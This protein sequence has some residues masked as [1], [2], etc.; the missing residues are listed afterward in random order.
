MAQKKAK[1][2]TAYIRERAGYQDE[3]AGKSADSTQKTK[4]VYWDAWWTHGVASTAS[5]LSL[6]STQTARAE[7]AAAIAQASS[8]L[9][10][11][12]RTAADT[13]DAVDKDLADNFKDQMQDN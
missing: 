5:N 12:L 3:A 8:D 11:A 4:D 10:V 13:Y 2:D 9:S 7:A 1:I 6:T